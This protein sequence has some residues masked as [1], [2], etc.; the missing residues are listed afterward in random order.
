MNG[1]TLSTISELYMC[2][3]LGRPK[4]VQHASPVLSG[5]KREEYP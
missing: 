3:S 1:H 5:P 4:G 2:R